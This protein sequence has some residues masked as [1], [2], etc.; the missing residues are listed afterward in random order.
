MCLAAQLPQG[1]K[2]T[3]HRGASLRRNATN[4]FIPRDLSNRR[5]NFLTRT[6]KWDG[7]ERAHRAQ[8]QIPTLRPAPLE[9]IPASLINK[10]DTLCAL[11]PFAATIRV[12]GTPQPLERGFWSEG[13]AGRADLLGRR[14][15]GRALG[16]PY[17][18]ARCVGMLSGPV[19][20]R[21]RRV[22]ARAGRVGTAPRRVGAAS[23]RVGQ[24]ARR[25]GTWARRIGTLARR[26]GSTPR[27]RLGR[28]PIRQDA[29][30]IRRD[31]SP[32][33]PGQLPARPCLTPTCQTADSACRDGPAAGRRANPL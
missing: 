19:G 28:V 4:K 31:A 23:G 20:A 13:Q 25:V 9:T 14:P 2:T 22:G 17:A 32:L 7:R 6:P 33:R 16:R 30:P 1:V 10:R 29:S 24:R 11:R 21:P 12:L 8:S 5:A 18:P 15:E 26:V 3:R 27:R